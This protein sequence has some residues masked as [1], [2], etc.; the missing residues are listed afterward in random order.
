MSARPTKIR[1]ARARHFVAP[2]V[3]FNPSLALGAALAAFR[4]V[5]SGGGVGQLFAIF[6]QS[7]LR[8]LRVSSSTALEHG[9]TLRRVEALC[10]GVPRVAA[11]RAKGIHAICTSAA[12]IVAFI[13]QNGRLA[14]RAVHEIRHRIQR[15]CEKHAFV[16][17]K[18]FVIQNGLHHA[19]IH[20]A[21]TTRLWANQ[22]RDRTV[23]HVDFHHS[24]DA[25]DAKLVP[26]SCRYLSHIDSFDVIA[27]TEFTKIIRAREKCL[28]SR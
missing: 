9:E 26:T 13:L 14:P 17:F 1:P 5:R 12:V 18:L 10:A 24:L 4:H 2:F 7:L 25:I 3:L 19:R 22:L 8:H 11:E 15:L 6:A 21:R 23:T 27:K 20:R 16:L 28:A